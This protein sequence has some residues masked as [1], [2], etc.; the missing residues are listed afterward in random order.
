MG[1]ECGVSHGKIRKLLSEL[2]QGQIV[3]SDGMINGLC[4]EF[5]VKTQ[6][7]KKEILKKLMTSPVMNV[8]FTN[9]SV[10]GKGAQVLILAASSGEAVLYLGR[11]KKG[12]AGIKGTPLE[13]YVGTLV[14]DHDRTF[15]TWI[16][17][18]Q[19][20]SSVKENA[21]AKA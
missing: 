21:D 3:L 13:S 2:T 11:E 10:N 1:N 7:E 15:Y 17:E 20:P 12:H 19:Q 14:H 5:S 8:D 18:R 16:F 6:K 9:A 4:R